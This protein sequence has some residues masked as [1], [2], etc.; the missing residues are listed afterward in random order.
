MTCFPST[1]LGGHDF[2][3]PACDTTE[4]PQPSDGTVC[5]GSQALLTTCRPTAS[6]SDPKAGCAN[7]LSCYRTD[8]A[9]DEGLCLDIPVCSVNQDCPDPNRPVCAS[10]LL[11]MLFPDT[12]LAGGDHLYCLHAGCSSSG[13][14]CPSGESCMPVALPDSGSPDICIPNCDKNLRCPP[15]FA[16]SR[17]V[18]GPAAPKVCVPGLPGLRCAGAEDCMLGDCVDTGV[19]FNIC[20]S[21]CGS[22][23]DCV[24]LISMRD[25]FVCLPRPDGVG[26]Y[27]AATGP[28]AG[29]PCQ[30]SRDCPAGESCFLYS[31]YGPTTVGE[32]RSP[33]GPSG[34]CPTLGGM[35]R[36]CLLGGAGGCY[37]GRFGLPCASGAE[38]IA[39]F[40]CLPVT[41]D[42]GAGGPLVQQVCTIPCSSDADC[43]ANPWTNKDGYCGGGFCQLAGAT[44][45]SC[46]RDAQCRTGRCQLP[47]AGI[48]QCLAEPAL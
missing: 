35:P 29:S 39:G 42:V 41:N 14:P 33:C 37:P 28:F 12:Q 13:S 36:V 44:G 6:T 1:Q 25:V 38:C 30:L 46:Q 17:L 27:C 5:V 4:A 32:C 26:G 47:P 34:D 16:C 31:P 21:S 18:S 15:N 9:R 45:A 48:G 23:K 11:T 3:A 7:G 20:T 43:D 2:C 10:A 40:S 8:L 19:G 22:D 24:P